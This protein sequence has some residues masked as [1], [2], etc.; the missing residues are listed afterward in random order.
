MSALRSSAAAGFGAGLARITLAGVA[1][2]I[3]TLAPAVGIGALVE[4]VIPSG[5]G[6]ALL[7]LVLLLALLALTAAIAHML[8]GSAIMRLEGQLAARMTAALWDRLLRL[9]TGFHRAYNSGDISMRA[10]AFQTLRD[11]LSGATAAAVLAVLF[12][13]P[14]LALLFFYDAV[15]GWIGLGT[16]IAAL[17]VTVAFGIAQIAPQRRR[18]QEERLLTGQLFQFIVSV[19]KL[20]AAGAEGL[21]RAIWA[22]R[23]RRQKLAE[24]RIN[25]QNEH[26]KAFGAAVPFLA[27]AMLFAAAH[28]RQAGETGAGEFIAI[29][30]ASMF[31]Y[32]S[33]VALGA[34]M[35][36][37]A[38]VVPYSEQVLPILAAAPDSG[39]GSGP[40]IVLRGGLRLED[41]SFRYGDKGAPVLDRVSIFAKPSEFI[42][43][44]GESGAGKSTL[45]RLALG[46]E[47]PTSGAVYYD[48]RNLAHLDPVSVRRQVGVVLQNGSVQTG[49]V[50]DNIIGLDRSL[51]LDDA[52]RAARQAVVDRDIAA[53]PMQMHTALGEQA[54]GVS[55]GQSQRIRV[56]AAL[57]RDPRIIFLDEAT[58][59]LDRKSQAALMEGIRNSTATRIVVAHR[60]ST[61]REAHRIYVIE[62]GRVVQVGRFD[63]LAGKDGL[64]RNLIQRQIS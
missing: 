17:A 16:G 40:P 10:L 54:A 33:I 55:G 56:A 37:I 23:Y 46:L 43:I 59:W 29:F 52:W 49:T 14:S 2:G 3:L 53:M 36:T 57:A 24:M 48:D 39:R 4:R 12:L 1:A 18:L 27:A 22:R 51:T 63:E 62:A 38:S 13:L 34:A 21:A 64:F 19:R 26:L 44:V 61:I 32:A 35:E 20:Q 45:I 5:A 25:I 41:V 6:V 15:L 9:Q 28:L 11:R 47:T 50:L 30:V 60:I 8:R 7:Q 31:F 58:N 42:A